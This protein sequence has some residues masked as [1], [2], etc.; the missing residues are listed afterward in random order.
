MKALP[1]PLH[2]MKFLIKSCSFASV[3][4]LKYNIHSSLAIKTGTMHK[5]DMDLT[6]EQAK[7]WHKKDKPQGKHKKTAYSYRKPLKD[8]DTVGK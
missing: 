7:Q 5:D 2:K 6:T 3:E 8:K 1:V 4:Q